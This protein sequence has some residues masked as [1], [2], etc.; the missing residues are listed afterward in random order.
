MRE[1][2]REGGREGRLRTYHEVGLGCIVIV[3]HNIDA[4]IERIVGKAAT[5]FGHQHTLQRDGGRECGK[6]GG[7]ET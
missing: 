4:V 7:R 5:C 6:E 2:E 3:S 1:R